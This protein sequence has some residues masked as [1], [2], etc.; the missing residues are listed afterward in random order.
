[1]RFG[2]TASDWNLEN[3]SIDRA[4]NRWSIVLNAEIADRRRKYDESFRT[5]T[6]CVRQQ[7]ILAVDVEADRFREKV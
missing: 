3:S 6:P 4:R 2:G 5:N 7:A 1:M